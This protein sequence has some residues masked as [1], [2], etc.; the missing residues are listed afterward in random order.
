MRPEEPILSVKDLTTLTKNILENTFGV[1]WITGEI[2]NFTRAA[3]GH[4]YFSLKDDSAQVRCAFFKT[5][6]YKA[7]PLQNG[8]QVLV[9]ACPSLYEA[10]GEFQ[11]IVKHIEPAGIG[12]LQQA[13]AHLK[14]LLMAEGLFDTARKRPIPTMPTH[15]CVITSSTGAA[16]HDIVRV[17]SKRCPMIPLILYPSLVQGADAPAALCHMLETAYERR[18]C[19]VLIVARGGGSLEDLWAFNDERVVRCLA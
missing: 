10:R 13:F 2:S 7:P 4:C 18:E 16:W 5:H 12:L 3:S 17:I 19:D 9:R 8:Q 1:L 14:A 6:S 11:L 15:I